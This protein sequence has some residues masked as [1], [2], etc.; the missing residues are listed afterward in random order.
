MAGRHERSSRAGPEG[1]G[2]AP[3]KIRRLMHC[4]FCHP[5]LGAVFHEGEHV[6]G[7]WDTYPVSPGHALLVTRRHVPD[8]FTAG[9]EEQRALGEA[10]E[11]ARAQILEKHRPDGFN[12][13]LNI[14]EAAGQSVP[15][16]HIHVIPAIGGT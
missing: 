15:H 3:T 12:V 7:L 11:L 1:G 9:P 4:P 16:L 14:G 13:G 10:I 8:W 5:D 2:A 6:L